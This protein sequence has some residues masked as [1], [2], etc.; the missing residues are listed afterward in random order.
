[1]HPVLQRLEQFGLYCKAEKCQ[2]GVSEVG[3]L[4]FVITPEGVVMES[5]QISTIENWPTLMSIRDVQ[6]LLGF[7]NFYRWFIRKYP[8]V[9]LPVKELLMKTD[10]AGKSPKGRPPRQ[11]SE[12]C[13]IVKWEWTGQ[14]VLVLQKLKRTF[15]ETPIHQDFDSAKPIILQM[16]ASGLAIAGCLNQNDVFGVLRPV[17]F[18]SRMCSPA[19]QNYNTYDWE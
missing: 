8:K 12:N 13:G 18:Y 4:G 10:I 14:A 7:T 9:T 6:V 5:D 3:F 1:V 19:E 15:T 11:K 16:D 2:F 17:N